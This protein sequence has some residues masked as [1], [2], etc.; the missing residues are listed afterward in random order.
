MRTRDAIK[1]LSEDFVRWGAD[2]TLRVKE[3][4]ERRGVQFYNY[5]DSKTGKIG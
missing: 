3:G 1:V 2:A 5:W 4:T